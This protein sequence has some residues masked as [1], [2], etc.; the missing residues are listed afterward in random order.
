MGI[1]SGRLV[2]FGSDV[3]IV[4]HRAVLTD[5]AELAVIDEGAKLGVKTFVI[6]SPTIYG[7]GSGVRP[8][9]STPPSSLR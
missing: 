3:M 7:I 2:S 9:S 1:R 5:M 6:M 8:L 4:M